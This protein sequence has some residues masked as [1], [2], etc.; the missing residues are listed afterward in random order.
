VPYDGFFQ[1][2]L[3]AGSHI[4]HCTRGRAYLPVLGDACASYFLTFMHHA[5]S[6]CGCG[7]LRGALFL[8]RGLRA[9]SH[10]YVRRLWPYYGARLSVL[11]GM[12]ALACPH[13]AFSGARAAEQ[14]A[15][16]HRLEVGGGSR[17]VPFSR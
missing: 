10:L 12:A 14:R 7:S 15:A 2:V 8:V 9:G 6:P 3:E 4:T 5:R 13:V 16:L 17:C 1:R 11:F